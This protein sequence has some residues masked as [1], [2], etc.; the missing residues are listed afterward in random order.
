MP[1]F[2]KYIFIG[3]A[4]MAPQELVVNLHRKTTP[5][6]YGMAL[7]GWAAMLSLAWLIHRF[8]KPRIKPAGLEVSLSMFFYA[9][10]ALCVEWGLIGNSPWKNPGANQ[11]GLIAGWVSVFILPRIFIE[12]GFQ[13]LRKWTRIT[14]VLF[15]FSLAL[16]LL[17]LPEKR[18]L[19][20]VFIYGYSVISFLI[21]TLWYCVAKW[22][23]VGSNPS[24][25]G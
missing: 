8:S 24:H 10:V 18:S 14:Y 2:L 23:E 16:P 12:E 19:A 11:A 25:R 13:T 1:D 20:A 6:L 7:L 22:R 15:L 17:L 21:L 3:L 4:L 5:L 9:G